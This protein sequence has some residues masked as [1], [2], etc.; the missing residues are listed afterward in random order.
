MST[1]S[2]NSRLD[3]VRNSA[4]ER[5]VCAPLYGSNLMISQGPSTGLGREPEVCIPARTPLPRIK[6]TFINSFRVNAVYIRP[7]DDSTYRHWGS[8]TS[9]VPN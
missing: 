1:A 6:L 7:S 3:N 8:G 2:R 4:A 9:R 5:F